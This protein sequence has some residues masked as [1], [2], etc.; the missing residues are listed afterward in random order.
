M[1]TTRILYVEDEPF[2]AKIVKESL[3]SRRYQVRTLT[4]GT[5]ILEVLSGF[6]PHLC[7]LD[8]MLPKV[9]GF[10]LAQGIRTQYPDLPIIFLTAKSRAEDAVKGFRSGGNDY[11]RKPFSLEELIVRIENL[12]RLQRDTGQA[13]DDAREITIGDYTFYPQRLE[14]HYGA[15]V[16]QL[17]HRE[18]E[19]LYILTANLQGVTY[20]RDILLEIWGDDH[21][22][23]SRNLDVYINKLRKYLAADERV[24]IVTL[25]GVGYLVKVL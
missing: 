3:E 13:R 4:E 5:Q 14:L 24:Q 17:S 19:L 7:V 21:L 23:N 8:V 15:Q 16:R 22:F 12:L 20:R 6:Q 25:K 1:N 9:D 2:M 10:T 18:S 11:L